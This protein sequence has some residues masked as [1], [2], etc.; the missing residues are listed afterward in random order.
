MEFLG[1]LH[2]GRDIHVSNLAIELCWLF[3]LLLFR[4]GLQH[5]F[6]VFKHLRA[7]LLHKG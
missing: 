1:L 3:L 6:C 7:M 5:F 4:R 2:N